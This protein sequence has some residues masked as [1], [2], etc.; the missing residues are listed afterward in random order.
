M[1]VRCCFQKLVG[2]VCTSDKRYEGAVVVP[3][4]SC[5]KDILGHTRSVG[6]SD[7]NSEVELILAR[8]SMFSP[9]RDIS[10]STICPCHRSSLGI[11]WC[12]GADRCPVPP[13]LS[14]HASKEKRERRT[15]E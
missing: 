5:Q 1:E 3:L 4:S 11:G 8:A 10:S 12:Q 13:G 2:G 9:P 14:K 15:L 7:I 6:V